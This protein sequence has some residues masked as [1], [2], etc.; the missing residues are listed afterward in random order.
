[1]A[2][3]L[4][5]LP[6]LALVAPI[7]AYNLV[8]VGGAAFAGLAALAWIEERLTGVPNGLGG[9]I[10]ALLAH[11]PSLAAAA[12]LLALVARVWTSAPSTARR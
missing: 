4:A 2:V 10:D 6:F 5:V 7:R 3:V 12:T 11:G 1:M 9:A 8:R